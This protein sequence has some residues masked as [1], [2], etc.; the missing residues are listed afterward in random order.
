MTKKKLGIIGGMGP[1]ATVDFYN[2]IVCHTKAS[3]DQEHLDI[4]IFNHASLIDRTYAI[5]NNKEEILLKELKEDLDACYNL[6]V[7]NIVI[8]CNTCHTILKDIESIS[9]VPI[10][11]M[12]EE[13]IYH[14]NNNKN[15]YQKIGLMATTGTIMSNMYQDWFKK[16]NLDLYIPNNDIQ[17]EIM[18]IIYDEVKKDGIY[19]YKHFEYI[20]QTFLNDGCSHVI[21]GCTELSHFKEK[22]K[23]NTIEPMDSLVKSAI[24]K[25]G[26]EYKE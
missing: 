4:V 22:Y 15:I 6:G 19:N 8:P 26:G 16:Y 1:L 3:I 13:T 14:I 24:I 18:S 7:Q 2:R 10:I 23:N 11:N 5:K 21:L 12:V 25:S 17:E 20:L 9:K